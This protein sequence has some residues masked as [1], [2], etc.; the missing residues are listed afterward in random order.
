[1]I[2]IDYKL[3]DKI[4]KYKERVLR[5]SIYDKKN[6]K[7]YECCP[8]CGN[9]HFIKFGRYYGIQRYRCKMCKKTFSNTTCSVWKYLKIKPE[10]WIKFIE[11]MKQGVSLKE[12]AYKLKISATTAFYWRHKFM[13]AIEN[14]YKPDTFEKTL[15]IQQHNVARCYKG[16]KNKHF[17][18]KESTC[19]RISAFYALVRRDI[20]ILISSEK[21]IPQIDVKY[22]DN[23]LEKIFEDRIITKTQQGCY[24]H[25]DSINN[26]TI[27]KNAIKNNKKLPK[28]VRKKY[29]FS[30][31]ENSIGMPYLKDKYEPHKNID[32]YVNRL[33]CWIYRFRGIASKY[34][35]HYYS[36]F[37]LINCDMKFDQ[38]RIFK[39]LLKNGSYTSTAQIACLH[40]ENY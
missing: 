29:G 7:K 40:L 36:F 30:I 9:K 8:Y 27:Q 11:L 3:M 24:I 35:S 32:M 38:V 18:S 6:V 16:S 25:L 23:T 13:H 12:C 21:Q 39:E 2:K 14:Y 28:S 22:D 33:Y 15:T 26:R 19:R 37:S 34:I 31:C 5:A 10:K 1:M 20:E 4:E 17:T